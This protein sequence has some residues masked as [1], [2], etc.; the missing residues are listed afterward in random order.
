MRAIAEG[1]AIGCFSTSSID[2]HWYVRSVTRTLD[3]G[4]LRSLVAVADC[5]GFQRAA[6]AL[7]LS[8][9]AVSQHM[10]RLE[11]AVG[12]ELVIRHGRGS[13]FTADGERLLAHARQ[14]LEM[15][16]NALERFAA[17]EQ[18]TIVIGT[19]EHG[20]AQ[21]IPYLSG[22]LEQAIPETRVRFRI[23]RG[24]RLREGLDAG[25]IDLAL[26]IGR[27]EDPRATP[28]GELA[29]TWYSSPSWITPQDGQA[30]AIAAFDS[31]CALRSSALDTLAA[32][33]IPAVIGA[34]AIQLAGVHAAVA[35]GLG[36]ALLATFGQAPEGLIPRDDL[37]TPDSLPLSVWSRDGLPVPIAYAATS[38]LRD[39]LGSPP[40]AI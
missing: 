20:A 17:T 11:A 38:A 13:R 37:P 5:G 3:I 18:A 22:R 40:T 9:A 16:D 1:D 2:I 29:L 15:H 10:R 32:H 30:V 14:I 25:R 35:A 34:E 33:R 12:R 4:P 31:P 21:I 24:M 19:T 7:Y 39:L 26:L 23:D 36:V 28:V 6:E 27:T 8:Q